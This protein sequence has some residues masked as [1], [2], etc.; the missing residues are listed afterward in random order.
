MSHSINIRFFLKLC[1]C[2]RCFGI[3]FLHFHVTVAMQ[4]LTAISSDDDRLY[5]NCLLFMINGENQK[6]PILSRDHDP[7]PVILLRLRIIEKISATSCIIH[8]D[9]VLMAVL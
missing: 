9:V 3:L 2:S 8:A 6:I 5:R 7:H 4:V 1:H